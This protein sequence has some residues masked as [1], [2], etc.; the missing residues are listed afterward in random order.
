MAKDDYDK[1]FL[2]NVAQKAIIEVERNYHFR[3]KMYQVFI[4]YTC[5]CTDAELRVDE[6]ELEEIKWVSKEELC[7]LPMFDDGGTQQ[8]VDAWV[9]KMV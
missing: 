6:S 3:T 9:N 4:V 8:V 7:R 5:I 2:G 1:H